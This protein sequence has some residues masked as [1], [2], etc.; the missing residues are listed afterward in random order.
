[1]AFIPWIGIHAQTCI[2]QGKVF[3]EQTREPLAFVN[4]GIKGKA[5][6]TF[7]DEQGFFQMEVPGGECTFVIC[8]DSC[9]KVS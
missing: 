4:I 5:A 2:V 8:D 9:Q 6:G 3:D 7:S 1:M